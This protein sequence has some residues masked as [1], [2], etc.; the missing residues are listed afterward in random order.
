[1]TISDLKRLS[2]QDARALI[3]GVIWPHGPTCPHC[4]NC[5][6]A[7]IGKVKANPAKR[8]REGLYQ[9]KECKP[10]RQFTVTKGTILEGSHLPMRTWV[11]IIASM[12]NG[13]K[14]VAA[15][16]LQRELKA[17]APNGD[18]GNFRAIWFACHR[19]RHAMADPRVTQLLGGHGKVIECD[20]TVVGG[21][22]RN[23]GDNGKGPYGNKSIVVT[24][25]ERGGGARSAVIND[26][27]SYTLR[28]HLL[29]HGDTASRLM[30]DEHRSYNWP[31]KSFASHDSTKHRQREYARGDVFSNTAESYFATLK[32][33]V[34]AVHHHWSKVHL[35]RY[36]S[37]RDLVWSTKTISDTDRVLMVIG[38]TVGK[39]LYYKA[40]KDGR[41]E[42]GI[43]SGSQG[44][45]QEA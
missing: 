35:H 2:E 6:Q 24:L 7:R 42:G 25:V 3:E 14:G 8:V 17:M 13:K 45:A 31:G 32:R 20:E 29:K 5:D 39:R 36:L 9:C 38:K 1:M 27:N 12:C 10:R 30:T 28:G 18:Y 15:R 22:P 33:S 37:E 40:P 19:V 34:Y 23:P 44:P 4:G 11:Y 43:L 41:W 21:K 16:Q 26:V